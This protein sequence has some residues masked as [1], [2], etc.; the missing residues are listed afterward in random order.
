MCWCWQSTS[1][2]PVLRPWK[3]FLMQ[4]LYLLVYSSNEPLSETISD[5]KTEPQVICAKISILCSWHK[6][7]YV[8]FLHFDPSFLCHILY[9][10]STTGWENVFL[11]SWL[12]LWQH[13]QTL[14]YCM[15]Y[16]C[17]SSAFDEYLGPLAILQ[18]PPP[19]NA[20]DSNIQQEAV[21]DA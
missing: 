1:P 6:C 14:H 13:N 15:S 20:G 7:E 21:F 17:D 19:S 12:P 16:C 4:P 18:C 10:D 9:N 8:A 11:G 3:I 2:L 5:T